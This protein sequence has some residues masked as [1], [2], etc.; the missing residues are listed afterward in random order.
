MSQ[1]VSPLYMLKALILV[2][3]GKIKIPEAF[4]EWIFL[5]NFAARKAYCA[6]TKTRNKTNYNI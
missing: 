1:A 3:V 2:V 5:A 4:V 6:P